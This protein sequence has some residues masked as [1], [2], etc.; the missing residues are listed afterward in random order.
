MFTKMKNIDSA[1]RHIRLFS[2]FF[3]IGCVTISC[4]IIYSSNEQVNRL[5]GKVYVLINGKLVEAVMNDRN[6]PVE[7]KDHISSFHKLFFTLSPDEKAIHQNLTKALYLADAS[8]RKQY[9]NLK[10][11][12]YYKDIIAGNISQTIELDSISLDM[13]EVPYKFTFFAKQT[14]TRTTSKLVRSLRSEGF[15]RT[16]LPQ[17]D[18]NVHG[19][20]IERW[21]ITENAD[22]ETQ[23]R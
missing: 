17:S 4:F 2:I 21:R 5:R 18:N 22:L 10:E 11:A 12:G 13:T 9:E 16:G 1:F 20:L 3:L 8:A 14:I 7:I 15:I 19:F 23:P 6:I